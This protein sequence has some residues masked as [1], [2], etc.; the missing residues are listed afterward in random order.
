VQL[1]TVEELLNGTKPSVP[2]VIPPYTEARPVDEVVEELT[3]F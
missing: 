3:L 1:F 2:F